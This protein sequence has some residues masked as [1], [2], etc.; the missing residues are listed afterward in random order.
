MSSEESLTLAFG[1]LSL[2]VILSIIYSYILDGTDPIT[3]F[4]KRWKRY[5]HVKLRK[6]G[7]PLV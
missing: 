4:N 5:K 3:M 1:I 6:K 7:G 2:I